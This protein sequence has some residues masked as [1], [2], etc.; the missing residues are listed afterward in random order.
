LAVINWRGVRESGA[1]FAVPT[2][3]F[4]VC[5]LATIA[6]GSIRAVA[7][8]GHPT[9][10]VPPPAAPPT[11]AAVSAWL[12]VRAFANGTTAMTGIEAVSNGVPI[13]RQPSFQGAR[14]TLAAI[15]GLLIAFLLGIAFLCRVY[16]VT[17]TEPAKAGYQ[18]V[19]SQLT[20][21]VFGRGIMYQI[22]MASICAVLAL[23][24]NTSFAGFPQ[25]TRLLA[26][27]GFLPPSF[28]VRGRRLAFSY[29]LL[30]LTALSG[31]LLIAFG[32]VTDRLIPLFAIGALLA[33]TTS[34]SGMVMHWHR[35]KVHGPRLW[36]NAIGATA[37]G[38]TVVLVLV[39]KFVE[40]AWIS[41]LI[42]LSFMALLWSIR[43][44]HDAVELATRIEGAFER[45]GENPPI[46]VVPVR[47]WDAV[48]LKGLQFA[49][50]FA[51]DVIAVQV[52]TGDHAE[53]D[54]TG[55][56][57]DL[58]AG[59]AE[60][61]G[62][63]PPELRVVQSEYRRQFAPLVEFVTGLAER[64]PERPVAVV[65]PELAERRWY[66]V[67][68]QSHPASMLRAMLLLRGGPRV[69]VISAPW[70]ER[71][72]KEESKKRAPKQGPFLQ[73]AQRA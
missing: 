13:F 29:G 19:L 52:L 62:L 45:G 70:Y 49:C 4:V 39:S 46:A 27:D 7:H 26:R 34:Q 35:L 60:R 24:A 1:A 23:S 58:V 25:L 12:L 57:H 11:T 22:S 44:H 69:V 14:R 59:P 53:E 31:A 36:I 6:I 40:G 61:Q 32:G 33:F 9:P 56:W 51:P 10:V 41:V 15:S 66:H 64:V 2:Y 28:E 30:V 3:L 37:T 54:L 47:R 48:S 21:A 72:W 17:A 18:S 43:R 5:L 65:V 38:V 73:R 67:L 50:S 20:G 16:H 63:K 42:V 8:G 55:Q 68:L 71:D